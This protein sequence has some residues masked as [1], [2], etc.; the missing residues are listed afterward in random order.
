[1]TWTL[2]QVSSKVSLSG[3]QK[4][5]NTTVVI[6]ITISIADVSTR[7][8][9]YI[10][11]FSPHKIRMRSVVLFC[12][13]WNWGLERCFSIHLVIWPGCYGGGKAHAHIS[14]SYTTS[15]PMMSLCPHEVDP[16]YQ[17]SYPLL[18]SPPWTFNSLNLPVLYPPSAQIS[19]SA[20]LCSHVSH[21]YYCILFHCS[22]FQLLN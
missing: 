1:M 16:W 4:T 10:I 22:I 18:H 17:H 15:S 9:T 3:T 2:Y 12:R 14:F 20:S 6:I 7:Y 5:F 13:W 21:Q 11:S 8:F 19:L